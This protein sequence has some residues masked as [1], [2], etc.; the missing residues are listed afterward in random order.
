M[1]EQNLCP[2]CGAPSNNRTNCEYCGSMLVRFNQLGLAFDP[3]RY[4]AQADTFNGLKDVLRQ[5][6]EEQERTNGMN[7]ITTHISSN[8]LPI[9]LDVDNP[10]AARDSVV[11]NVE[12]FLTNPT[13]NLSDVYTYPK[14]D[15]Q[16]NEQSLVIT[17]YFYEFNSMQVNFDNGVAQFNNYQRMQHEKFKQ[18][19]EFPLFNHY[20]DK[21][22]NE[23][24]LGG[25]GK[26]HTY[27]LDFGK[28]FEGAAEVI[29]QYLM[30]MYD[31]SSVEGIALEYNSTSQT[32][33]EYKGIVRKN[34]GMAVFWWLLLVVCAIIG[35][36]VGA[37]LNI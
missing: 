31:I 35:A 5:H 26:V 11:L 12:Q 30:H 8:I 7:H 29:T 32:E 24:G 4:G 3:N 13:S 6:L 1:A 22:K 28:D 15:Y 27:S 17:L 25:M 16:G 14:T 18:F 9:S 2:S 10:R 21:M 19:R 34:K 23:Y 36:I 20:E 37:L 33:E